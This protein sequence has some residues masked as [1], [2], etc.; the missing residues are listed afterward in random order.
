MS[1]AE[2]RAVFI[3]YSSDD[4]EA[5]Q[6]IAS[7][8]Q[9]AGI[10][11]WF[12]RS[13]LRGGDAWDQN[14][15]RQI[16]ECALFLPIISQTTERRPEGYFR[17]EW[18]LADNRTHHMGR[19]KSFLVP[20][21]IDPEVNQSFADVPDSFLAVHWTLLPG[22]EPNQGFVDNVKTLLSGPNAADAGRTRPAFPVGS[23]S[24]AGSDPASTPPVSSG[25]PWLK[26]LLIGG[27][28]AVVLAGV[29][30]VTILK[31]TI[32]VAE[33]K[34]AVL[35]FEDL[36][37]KAGAA[38]A[39]ADQLQQD[40]IG[41]LGPLID[42]TVTPRASVA[43]YRANPKPIPDIARELI[44]G[45]FVYGTI[46]RVDDEAQVTVSLITGGNETK[47]SKTYSQLD[48][49]KRLTTQTATATAIADDLKAFFAAEREKAQ[50]AKNPTANFNAISAYTE[51]LNAFGRERVTPAWLQ[52]QE[53]KLQAVVAAVP[54]HGPAWG[55]LGVV[56][57]LMVAQGFDTSE[58]RVTFAQES[59]DSAIEFAPDSPDTQRSQ[60]IFLSEALHNYPDAIAQFT[61]LQKAQPNS[62]DS[63][64]YLGAVYRH[65]G[66]W[67]EATS[68]LRNA[69]NLEPG[70]FTH[71]RTLERLQIDGRNF[72]AARQTRSEILAL[73]T[74]GAAGRAGR[75][76]AGG[77]GG[78]GGQGDATVVIP[79]LAD[80]PEESYRLAVILLRG[81]GQTAPGDK[82]FADLT[83]EQAKAP[84]FIAL[85]T[86]WLRLTNKLDEAILL[87]KQQ[88]AFA[89]DG[90]PA[91]RQAIDMAAAYA[92][93][94]DTAGAR[95]RLNG[96]TEALQARLASEPNNHR[97]HWWLGL[98]FA[99]LD[100]KDDALREGNRAVEIVPDNVD[101]IASAEAHL[102]L[103]II[104]SWVGDIDQALAGMTIAL[105]K[106]G[107][108]ATIHSMKS[109]PW[110]VK[111]RADP[112]FGS[113]LLTL[114]NH[115]SLIQDFGGRGGGPGGRGGLPGQNRGGGLGGRGGFPVNG[116]GGP[117]QRGN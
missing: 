88:P 39:F 51:V 68:N 9:E 56:H 14:I 30:M 1:S 65:Q 85:K 76:G 32:E 79:L 53:K 91:W 95:N 102:R 73:F 17:L 74:P 69:T 77:L 89:D 46:T 49:S 113:S 70:N 92:A 75:G 94:G 23:R 8:L 93:N 6:R 44:V 108:E 21:C 81:S 41:K 2:S 60:G 48:L 82:L 64:G 106:P 114:Q 40:L 109:D 12:D 107:C 42:L 112:R 24:P 57:S 83:P 110:F 38:T 5:A 22:G 58:K 15:R 20:V 29:G 35:P 97:L 27:A 67:A 4:V 115:A 61:E 90:E 78:R 36:S 87:D 18:R 105:S 101:A 47:W 62:A 103:A 28:I 45:Y 16:K 98:A 26:R 25:R 100:K 7:A 72:D 10:E 34:I 33:K 50:Q 54:G 52:A 116:Q 80:R 104:Q 86:D 31:K 13:E 19:T 66:K 59:I 84:R 96:V 11:V 117:P 71:L 111:M 99:V 3:S 43:Q 37:E 63:Y 55:L